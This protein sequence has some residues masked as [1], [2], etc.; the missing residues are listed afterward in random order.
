[1]LRYLLV[2]ALLVAMA[3]AQTNTTIIKS[4]NLGVPSSTMRRDAPT[5]PSAAL[6]SLNLMQASSIPH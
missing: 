1:M 4:N 6:F 3:A 5:R 2:V